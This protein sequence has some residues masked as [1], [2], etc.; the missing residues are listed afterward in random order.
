[1]TILR[2]AVKYSLHPLCVEDALKLED[3]QPK[4][5]KYGSHYFIVMPFFRLARESREVYCERGGR[6]EGR[7]GGSEGE[8]KIACIHIYIPVS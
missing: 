4:V 3:Q 7:E 2:F 8:N 1:L 5:N 6:K